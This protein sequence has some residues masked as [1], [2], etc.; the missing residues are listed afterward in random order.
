MDDNV[1]DPYRI[2][3]V[4]VLSRRQRKKS[5]DIL[6]DC[7]RLGGSCLYGGPSI[8]IIN[9]LKRPI[10]K[11]RFARIYRARSAMA[12]FARVVIRNYSHPGDAAGVSALR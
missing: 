10:A 9:I 4:A 3:L 8:D 1:G 6:L 5:G 11:S 7:F 12:R 2:N